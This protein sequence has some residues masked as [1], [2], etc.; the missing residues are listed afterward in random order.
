VRANKDKKEVK[1]QGYRANIKM[2]SKALQLMIK[3]RFF[4]KS[5][6]SM[7]GGR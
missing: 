5:N 6:N 3:M 7:S 4:D 2:K 1:N